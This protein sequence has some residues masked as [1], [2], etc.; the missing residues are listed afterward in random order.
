MSQQAP[1]ASPPA[2]S[3]PAP[4]LAAQR[5]PFELLLAV[6]ARLRHCPC[7]PPDGRPF[8][9]GCTGGHAPGAFGRTELSALRQT[10]RAWRAAALREGLSQIVASNRWMRSGSGSRLRDIGRSHA[11]CVR[12]LVFRS[13]DLYLGG[14]PR[15]AAADAVAELEAAL[16]VGWP[17]LEAVVI[18]WF[19]G[20]PADHARIAAALRRHAPRIRELYVRDRLLSVTQMAPLVWGPAGPA[21][22]GRCA[23]IRRLAIKPYGYNQHWDAL[24]PSESG[25]AEI[26]R[27]AHGQ[28]TS[29]AVGGADFTPELLAALQSSQPHLT[30]LSVEHA[31]IGALDTAGVRLPSVA[32]LHLENVIF[33]SRHAAVLPLTPHMFPRLCSLTLRH[34]WQR[35]AQPAAGSA[36]GAALLQEEGWLSTLWAHAWP[37][38]R[39]LSLPAIADIDAAYLPRA[40]PALERLTTTSMDYSGPQLSAGGL[41]DVLRGLPRLRHLA[42][43]QR[44]A[45]GTPGYSFTG[46]ALSRLVGADDEDAAFSN[47]ML[48]S[49]ASTASTIVAGSPPPASRPATPRSLNADSDT[50]MDTD[51]EDATSM[52]GAHLQPTPLL[53]SSLNTLL[54]PRA[55]FTASTLGV[56]VQQLPALV[57]LSV[58]LRSD[59]SLFH[60]GSG[61]RG[62]KQWTHG[63]LRWIGLSAD[64]DVLTDP[65]WLAA[66]LRERFPGLLECS[67][68][69]ARSHWRTVAGLSIVAPGIRFTRLNS[70]TPQTASC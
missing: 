33:G 17:C 1:C 11:A 4:A 7:A 64:E 39:A 27:R 57:R 24:L 10:S 55:P 40:C 42:I 66:W 56:L 21:P 61:A 54:I 47:R 51:T 67:T 53:S 46:A 5:L 69:H 22:G 45:D 28:L 32:D 37:H 23:A 59:S 2:A 15:A 68:N 26:A 43:E 31:W 38:L 16:A 41:V 8:S 25:A 63:S 36:R 35:S 48:G 29:L 60:I 3:A 34:V 30:H 20:S 14:P 13:S 19:S 9:L 58:A 52:A 70:H 12:R 18:G 49:R 65:C 44:Q 6:C 50:D 62:Q